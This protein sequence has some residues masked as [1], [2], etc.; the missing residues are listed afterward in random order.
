MSPNWVSG[1]RTLPPRLLHRHARPTACP[2][3]PGASAKRGN[4]R[5]AALHTVATAPICWDFQAVR[6]TRPT[7]RP[8]C[9]G[10]LAVD[11]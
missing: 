11:L 2:Q 9:R 8:S 1:S 6:S 4:A 10:R 5:A 7:L 3:G